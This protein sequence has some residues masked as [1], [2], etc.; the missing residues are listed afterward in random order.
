[1][2]GTTKTVYT[3]KVISTVPPA[4]LK[5]LL[6]YFK[7]ID[8]EAVHD[9]VYSV[10]PY[11]AYKITM[12]FDSDFWITSNLTKYHY[13]TATDLEIQGLYVESAWTNGTLTAFH[14]YVANDYSGHLWHRLQQI[15]D[16][17]PVADG[18]EFDNLEG[19]T[20]STQL[21]VEEVVKQLRQ[22]A[23]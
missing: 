23:H 22:S 10:I 3:D 11:P 8:T 13:G 1:M 20:V 2:D 5:E 9:L 18:M 17:Y 6:P 15:G 21:L 4:N 14:A 16:E 7:P 12:I 19:M